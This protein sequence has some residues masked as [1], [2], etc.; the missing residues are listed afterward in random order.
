MRSCLNDVV[1]ELNAYMGASKPP[2]LRMHSDQAREFLSQAVMESLMHHNIK[3][4]FTSIA[5]PSSNGVAERWIDLVKV[6]ATVLLASRYLPTTFWF[7]C[8]VGSVHL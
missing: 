5:D 1:A 3:Q 2:V 6:K 8:S 7:C 4:T